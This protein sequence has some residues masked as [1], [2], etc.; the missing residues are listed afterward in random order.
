MYNILTQWLELK[1][2]FEM[3]SLDANVKDCYHARELSG[4]FKNNA[5]KLYFEFHVPIVQEMEALNAKFQTSDPNMHELHK[6]LDLQQLH[7]LCCDYVKFQE[8]AKNMDQFNVQDIKE[9]Y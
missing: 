8:R 1:T 2:Y 5:N 6:Q 4:M 7:V 9:Q 3:A